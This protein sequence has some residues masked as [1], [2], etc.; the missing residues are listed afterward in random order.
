MCPDQPLDSRRAAG[1]T[2]IMW[3]SKLE[4]YITVLPTTSS[5]VLPIVLSVPGVELSAHICLYLPTSGKEAESVSAL[6]SLEVCIQEIQEDY[7]CPIYLR[8]DFNVNPNNV[9]R[10]ALFK[11][12]RSKHDL[13]SLDLAH[14]THHHFIGNGK[15]D[16]QLDLI[17]SIGPKPQAETL[18]TIICKLNNP[19]VQ[20]NH[21]IIVTVLPLQL[22]EIDLPETNLVAPKLQNDRVKIFWDDEDIDNYQALISTNLSSIRE[23][24]SNAAS[25]VSIA[26]LLSQ[27]NDILSS[28]AKASNKFMKLGKTPKIR[29]TDNPDIKLAQKTALLASKNVR[30]LASSSADSKQLEAAR[31][32]A[33]AASSYLRNLTRALQVDSAVSRDKKLFTILEKNPAGLFKSIKSLKSTS[34]T[35]IQ[36]LKVGSKVYT[37][38]D[39]PNGF[40][41]SLSALKAPDMSAVYSSSSYKST[42]SDYQHIIKICRN[43]IKIPDI[44]AKQSMELL[45]SLKPDVND[46]YSITPKH[47][48]N[49]GMEG[50]IHFTFLLNLLISNVNLSSLEELNSV[51]AMVLHKGHGKDRESDR[52]Y[53]TISTC[54]FLAKA[55]D[56][57]VGSLYE[58]GWA[59]AQAETQFQGSGSS[60]E[61][62]ALLLTEC[63]KYS[64][65]TARSPLFCIFLDA[66]SAFDKI[67]R[68]FCVKSAYLA[69]S[70]D[71]GLLFLDNR[72][73]C[74]K[75]FV[76]WDRI[77][78]G[79]IKDV[80]GVEQGGCNSDRIYKLANN[81]ELILTQNSNLGLQMGEVHVASVG[82][83]DDVALLSD[84]PHRLQCLLHLA[85][86][87][88]AEYHV[89]M[90]PEKT[91][92]LCYT[93]RGQKY[94]TYYLKVASP[95]SM[96][97]ET[98]SFSEDAEHVGILRSTSAGNMANILSR[99]AAHT[100]ALF[101][102]LPA[103]L[104]RGHHGNPAASTRVEKMYGCPV[105]LSGL[106]SLVLSKT[107]I[108]SLDHHYKLS[109]ERLQ[110]LYKGT[111][112]PVVHF[113]A[114][115]LPAGALLHL[116][117]FSVLGMI[118]RLGPDNILFRHGYQVLSDNITAK[119]SWFLQVRELC[120]QYFLPDPLHI[121]DNP[122]SKE[123]FKREAKQHV[124]DWWNTKLRADAARLP[125]LDFFR[126]NFMSLSSPHPIWTSAGSSPYEVQKATV[127]ARMLS[128]RYRTCWLRRHW[129]GD[130]T[131]SCRVPGCSGEPG[132][133]KHLA[134]GECPGLAN[135]LV[136]A[137]ALWTSFLKENPVLFPVVKLYSLGD[138]D[139]FLKFLL[140]P[141][142]LPP[143]IS[144]AQKHGS[145]VKEQLCYMTRTWL[146]YMHKE[147]LKLLQLWS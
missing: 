136:R 81:K 93:P 59:A 115:S 106:A 50:A 94:Q 142:T 90:V 127:Q 125:S 91:K 16:T 84:D 146:Y 120:Q 44:S 117:Q 22:V 11:H 61:L 17:L 112:S 39:V 55:L 66:K 36:K 105:L 31:A 111:P 8:G 100:R 3:R 19:L 14:P 131:G 121:L 54:P 119:Q 29:P 15:F 72:M 88:A 134:T 33:A 79:P 49:A 124:I 34:S 108:D 70:R 87:Y 1:G 145:L 75:T 122:P 113:L 103:G 35:Q 138:P 53:R 144:L 43:G 147:R 48:L 41:D 129:S 107:E 135:A 13:F 51:W 47:F 37:G 133:L 40:F 130:S 4:P 76:E 80:L 110:R 83:A 71:Q 78:M 137:T 45:L 128:G 52:S 10:A 46:L 18:N 98:V 109:L 97:G 139:G 65:F 58:S 74:R 67:I 85:M 28:A 20:S 60:H 92:L 7:G 69:G 21:D 116:R 140:D 6:A 141:T 143:V 25:P 64:L 82:Q 126:A 23:R 89:E 12:F 99:Q 63:I 38:A 86:E 26:I 24:W 32:E 30:Q 101:A 5:S 42:L 123:K 9:S 96:L 104:A 68:E 2:M 114:G 73:K 57:Y 102:V 56:K 77:L 95:I 132:T 118:A 27:T 62:A